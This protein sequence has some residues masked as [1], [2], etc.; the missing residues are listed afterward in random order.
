M[1]PY[2]LLVASAFA[3]LLSGCEAKHSGPDAGAATSQTRPNAVASDLPVI[4]AFP[5]ATEV[6]LFVET[7]T[8]PNGPRV[9][10]EPKG[11]VLTIDQRKAFEATLKVETI[12]DVV[13]ACFV[14]HHFFGYYDANG[15]KL[16]EISICFC[17]AGASV[18]GPSGIKMKK[19]QWLSADFDKVKKFV[20]S[21]N[22]P[23]NVQCGVPE[24]N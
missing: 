24:G 20:R 14:P 5:G 21:L 7:E 10:T 3:I 23:T 22:L 16:G 15:E 19:D 17:C 13:A 1:R 11:R 4:G 9:F 2:F 8:R 12:P 18:K 6:R